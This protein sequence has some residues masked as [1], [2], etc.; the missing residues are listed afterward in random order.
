M[1][2]DGELGTL[3]GGEGLLDHRTAAWRDD[4]E[5]PPAPPTTR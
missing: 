4:E 5:N 1:T 2:L 3:E